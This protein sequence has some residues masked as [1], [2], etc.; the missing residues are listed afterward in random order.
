[1]RIFNVQQGHAQLES[2]M[3]SL[4]QRCFVAFKSKF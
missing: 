4:N 2:E 1:M 3:W